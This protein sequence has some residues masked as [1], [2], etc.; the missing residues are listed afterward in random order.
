MIITL[1]II[2]LTITTRRKTT[3]LTTVTLT[4]IALITTSTTTITATTKTI[5]ITT[6]SFCSSPCPHP[7]HHDV[8]SPPP[9]HTHPLSL[10]MA[11]ITA[12]TRVMLQ[13]TGEHI[14]TWGRRKGVLQVANTVGGE[15]GGGRDEKI[16]GKRL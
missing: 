12:L 9:T 15:K 11:A 6:T 5:A 1:T 14:I 8:S 4:M 2:T 16:D 10:V 3:T 7:T 13:N